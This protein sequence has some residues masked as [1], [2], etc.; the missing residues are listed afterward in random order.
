LLVPENNQPQHPLFK[1]SKDRMSDP[2]SLLSNDP[3]IA[4]ME[5][6]AREFASRFRDLMQPEASK[7]Q[8]PPG[9]MK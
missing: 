5:Q 4:T 6:R 3:V 1:T 8:T 7:K 2:P 9:E